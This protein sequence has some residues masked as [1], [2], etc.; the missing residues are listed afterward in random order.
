MADDPYA[1]FSTPV[2][3]AEAD[4]YAG[5]ASVQPSAPTEGRGFEPIAK[6]VM[7]RAASAL[8]FG[9]IENVSAK[10]NEMLGKGTYDENLKKNVAETEAA[11]QR[12]GTAGTIAS[13]LAGG[14]GGASVLGKAG[15]T[16]L[17][18]LAPTAGL[19][20]R[21]AAGA[22]EGAAYGAAQGAGHTYT[23]DPADYGQNALAG[24]KT[25]ALVGAAA[26]AVLGAAGK[27][28]TPFATNPTR[29]AAVQTLTDAGVPVSA[30]N[31]TGS[32]ALQ[33][34]EDVTSKLPFGTAISK[35]PSAESMPAL[36]QA[37]AIKAGLP[38]G[39]IPTADVL[40]KGF[41]TV[42]GKIGAIQKA[43]PLQVDH[44][45]LN[46]VTNISSDIPMLLQGR[47]GSAQ[48]FVDKI[49]SGQTLSPEVAQTTRTQLNRAIRGQNGPNGDKE[50]Q[51]ILLDLKN[52][53]DDAL[54][55]TIQTSGNAAHVAQLQQLRQQY[56]NLHTLS[57]ALFAS[58]PRGQ[59]GQLTTPGALQTG[60]ARALGKGNYMQ[61]KGDLH[62]ACVSIEGY[63]ST[64]PR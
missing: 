50:Y 32:A 30:G 39:E 28:I 43:Y 4:P 12:L 5:I 1:A 38:A 56:A 60:M 62:S 2:A 45:L 58:G 61:G 19:G 52:S 25:G 49:I 64:G 14:V 54:T 26:P 22:T 29:Q 11:G 34:A 37:V 57:D 17:G 27:I 48:H 6:D 53:L 8:T 59:L 21:T 20:L 46:E 23:N 47:Q 35:N 63:P 36:T 24:A 55:R 44:T 40:K 3:A 31:R 42:G 51:G 41:D 9:K 15:V 18:R 7:T 16:L 33:T 13:D 10:L